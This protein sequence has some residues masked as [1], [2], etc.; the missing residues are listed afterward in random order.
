MKNLNN[1]AV[2]FR[3][4]VIGQIIS[5]FGASVLRFALDT[6]VLDITKRAD[7]YEY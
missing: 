7:I 4:I 1:K 5:I 6:Y 3:I 2:S